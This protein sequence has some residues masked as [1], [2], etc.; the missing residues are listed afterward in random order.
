MNCYTQFTYELMDEN[1]TK[2]YPPNYDKQTTE[3]EVDFL[4]PVSTWSLRMMLV[5]L[6]SQQ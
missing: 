5:Q 1:H 2:F 6:Y 3:K 4:L